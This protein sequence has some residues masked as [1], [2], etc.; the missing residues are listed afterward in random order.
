MFAMVSRALKGQNILIKAAVCAL[1]V[2]AIELVF[3]LI[4]NVWLGMNVWDYSNQPFNILGQICPI[5]SLIWAG[6]AL[7]F[8]PLA[9]AINKSYV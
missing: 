2:T 3:G 8:L 5:F 1:G 9:D 4:F 7:V 6:V